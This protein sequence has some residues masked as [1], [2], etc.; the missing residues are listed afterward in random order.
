M[1]KTLPLP[2]PG[3]RVPLAHVFDRAMQDGMTPARA[4]CALVF[5]A[6][7]GKA[8]VS[9]EVDGTYLR[10]GLAPLD[11]RRRCSRPR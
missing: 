5:A 2:P 1:T 8:H 7:A 10:A 3:A 6:C 9:N 4:C 11:W